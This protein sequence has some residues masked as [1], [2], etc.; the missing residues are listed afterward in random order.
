MRWSWGLW[1]V[2]FVFVGCGEAGPPLDEL[3]LRDA[4]R[5]E[6]EIVAR[7]PTAARQRL[8]ARLDSARAGDVTTD[9][10]AGADPGAPAALVSV[11]DQARE[12]RSA[13][14]LMVGAIADG[15]ARPVVEQVAMGGAMSAPLPVLEGESA[16]ATAVLEARALDGEA[17][18]SLRALLAGSGARRLWRVVGWPVGAIAIGDIAY[19]NA[20]WL[21]G[22]APADADGD[23]DGADGSMHSALNAERATSGAAATSTGAIS[24]DVVDAGAPSSDAGAALAATERASLPDLNPV[25][26]A[27]GGATDGG[28]SQPPPPA[29]SPAPTVGPGLLDACAAGSDGCDSSDD[30]CSGS[31]DDGSDDSCSGTSDDGS[32]DSCSTPPDDGSSCQVSRGG[33]R[34][35]AGT[36]LW[37]LAPLGFL[38]GRRP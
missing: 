3:P 8:A 26:S 32:D 36:V 7:L 29:P 21:V 27:T 11:L 2:Q 4:L 15:I 38:L 19:V 12:R 14:S 34:A 16:S 33:R 13:E 1:L 37:L 9:P 5:A 18:A 28:V 6:P 30:S 25:A 23:G 17:G 22:L 24:S 20:S 10:V 31:T 35:H